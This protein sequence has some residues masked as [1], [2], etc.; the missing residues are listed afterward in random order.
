MEKYEDTIE[1]WYQTQPATSIKEF[2]QWLCIDTAKV[3]CPAGT[4]GKNCRRCHYGDNEL[5]CSGR[6]K[7]DVRLSNYEN[8]NK[9]W[10]INMFQGDGKRLGNGRCQCESSYAGTNCSKCQQGYV[11][12]VDEKNQLVCTGRRNDIYKV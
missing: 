12:S 5:I 11:A 6:G 1:D 4:F 7:C 3:C 2:Y 8:E 9:I 10:F